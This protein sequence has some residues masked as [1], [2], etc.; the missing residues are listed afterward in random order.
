M[1]VAVVAARLVQFAAGVILFGAPLFLL[2]GYRGTPAEAL[3]WPRRVLA[4][5]AAALLVGALVSLVA[6]TAV[7][8]GDPAA[9]LD[10]EMLTTVAGGTAFGIAILVRAGAAALALA[11]ALRLPS[12]L[13]LWWVGSGLGAVALATFA[14]T[15][16]GAAE[17]GL[18]GGIHA[19]ADVLHLLA[20]GVWLGALAA[21]ALI[22]S[23]RWTPAPDLQATHAALAGF[24]GV[25]SLVV[26]ALVLTGLVNSWFLVG[27]ERILAMTGS[28]YGWLL[29]IKL[30]LFVGMLGLAAAN[31]F[32]HTPALNTALGN[33]QT[34]VAV[35]ELRRSIRLEAAAGL[36]VLGL[37]SALGVL[38]PVS[39][40]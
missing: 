38:A 17:P 1:D 16:H 35:A 34:A 21:L 11:A 6:Q 13:G 19:A 22:L 15:G 39:A 5:S 30:G 36:A 20:A 25:G 24:S 40:Q 26:A 3:P 37:V 7:M 32:R 4:A 27:P 14:W 29:L 2:Y 9:A 8:A 23:A 31:R 12:G 33:G 18:A 28:A 10:P